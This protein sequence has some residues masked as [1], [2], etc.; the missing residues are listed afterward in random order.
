MVYDLRSTSGVDFSFFGPLAAP[1]QSI[2][3]LYIRR[4]FRYRT[5]TSSFI[6]QDQI[7]N[8]NFLIVVMDPT[9]TERLDGAYKCQILVRVD[10]SLGR[11]VRTEI[12]TKWRQAT[13][14]RHTA[15]I[16]RKFWDLAMHN[17][18]IHKPMYAAQMSIQQ[19]APLAEPPRSVS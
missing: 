4:C 8:A 5:P 7:L 14:H 15:S 1:P 11:P 13:A 16:P 2:L 12:Y 19:L 18:A 3:P 10:K 6:P 17:H 9:T